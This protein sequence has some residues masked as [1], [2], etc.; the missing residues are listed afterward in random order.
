MYID[1]GGIMGERKKFTLLKIEGL[2]FAVAVFAFIVLF[3]LKIVTNKFFIGVSI[4]FMVAVLFSINSTIQ[5]DRTSR[6]ISKLNVFV[7]SLFFFVAVGL[8]VYG[9]VAGLL[10]F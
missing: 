6:S 3:Y 7:S 9:Y 1:L 5:E 2:L 10:T 4:L 8:S